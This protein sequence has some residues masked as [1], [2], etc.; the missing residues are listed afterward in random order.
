MK[1]SDDERWM[2]L[3]RRISVFFGRD[4]ASGET[5]ERLRQL[6][7]GTDSNHLIRDYYKRKTDYIKK[8]ALILLILFILLIVSELN[9]P[10]RL[11]GNR[12]IRNGYGEG[13]YR[14][15]LTASGEGL[16]QEEFEIEV[17]EQSPGSAQLKSDMDLVYERLKEIIIGDN[18]ATDHIVSDLNLPSELNEYPFVLEWESENPLII[19]DNGKINKEYLIEEPQNINLYL[20]I[21]YEEEIGNYT[22]PLVLYP[23]EADPED[24]RRIIEGS[25]SDEDPEDDILLP[26]SVGET[27]LIWK[28]KRGSVL[29]VYPIAAI[30]ILVAVWIGKDEDVISDLKKRNEALTEEYME[31]VIGLQLLLSSGTT[32]RGAI[33]QLGGDYK[34]K[35]E[36]GGSRK[37]VY[38]E[39][40]PCIRKLQEG[41]GEVA[42]YEYF[43]SRCNIPIYRKLMGILIQNLTKGNSGLI[44]SLNG[45]IRDTFDRRKNEVKRIG[46]EASVKLLLPMM[47][48]LVMVMVIIMIP[49]FMSFG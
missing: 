6:Y 5:A 3:L 27:L 11:E 20:R 4:I 17:R 21:C 1:K 2:G 49:A 34:R 43:A 31:F 15:E 24:V 29:F 32:L 19:R 22:I 18:I 37:Y 23:P 7:P 9:K 28:E 35:R 33:L 46:E 13:E 48:L 10:K 12:L 8:I 14:I 47:M 36:K 30:L 26:E 16:G 25:I 40:L 45:E 44:E 42:C 39:M 38:E 41:M